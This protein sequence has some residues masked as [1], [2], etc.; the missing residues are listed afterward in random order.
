VF[1]LFPVKIVVLLVDYLVVYISPADTN[2]DVVVVVVVFYCPYAQS[3][4]CSEDIN[5]ETDECKHFSVIQTHVK[6]KS[7]KENTTT[8][9]CN[10]MT[11]STFV[12][13]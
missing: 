9:K 1:N 4:S 8:L 5:V 2:T 6:P 13:I 3:I 11:P 10:Q 7:D 12:H